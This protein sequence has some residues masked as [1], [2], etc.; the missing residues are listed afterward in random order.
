MGNITFEKVLVATLPI[1]SSIAIIVIGLVCQ[2]IVQ[3]WLVK[4]LQKTK[5]D[6]MLHK[7][8]IQIV[9]IAIWIFV[10]VS[11][12][13]KLG[14]DSSSI[15]TVIAACGAAVAL[16][17][18]GSLSNLASGIIIMMSSIFKS[19]DYII[20]AGVEGTVKSI[21]LLFTTIATDDKRTITIPN[22]SLT[23][24]TVTNVTASGVRRVAITIGVAYASD[25]DLARKTIADAVRESKYALKEY[26]IDCDVKEYASSSINI[27]ARCWVKPE[28]YWR[29][30]YDVANRIK[31][32]LDKVGIEIAFPQ[33][34]VHMK[35]Q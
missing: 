17:L 11:V 24:N 31:P 28:D 6:S 21:D 27:Y 19:G 33:I 3:K 35:Q 30:S 25:I 2:K 32:A 7:F 23:G 20:A 8:L 15:V 13:A 1:I 34:D 16:A 5:L 22:A 14:I 29:A 10:A 18:Q 26:S 12:L 4:G 9:E